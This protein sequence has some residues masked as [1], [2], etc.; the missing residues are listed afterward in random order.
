MV[1][2]APSIDESTIID[3]GKTSG[4]TYVNVLINERLYGLRELKTRFKDNA[5]NV[6]IVGKYIWKLHV[7]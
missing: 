5:P 7:G 1:R 3:F 4:R 6:Y 2:V